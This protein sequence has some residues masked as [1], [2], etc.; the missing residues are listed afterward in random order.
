MLDR[1]SGLKVSNNGSN[2]IWYIF[3]ISEDVWKTDF[4]Y[5]V[6]DDGWGRGGRNWIDLTCVWYHI[7]PYKSIRYHTTPYQ[8]IPY[9]AIPYQPYAL[10]LVR[11]TRP[12]QNQTCIGFRP[13]YIIALKCTCVMRKPVPIN[14]YDVHCTSQK[15][16]I[17][18]WRMLYFAPINIAVHPKIHSHSSNY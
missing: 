17:S 3:Q 8:T 5:F 18:H 7:I 14:V 9:H 16:Q 13:R 11:W 2:Q 1:I 12:P 10:D 6:S 4:Q 15:S